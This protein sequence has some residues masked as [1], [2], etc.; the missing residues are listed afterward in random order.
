[1]KTLKTLLLLTSVA[2]LAACASSKNCGTSCS[3]KEKSA[4]ST[5]T[6]CSAG[7]SCS[8]KPCAVPANILAAA[9]SSVPGFAMTSYDTDTDNGR[10]VY[11]LDGTANG[12]KCEIKVDANG[13]VLK[14]DRD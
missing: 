6:S 10:K 3:S 11:E 1:M 2:A 13:K 9:K 5:R 7:T 12:R 14:I 4:C 8:T